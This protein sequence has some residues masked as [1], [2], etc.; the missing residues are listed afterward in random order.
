VSSFNTAGRSEA[1]STR[2]AVDADQE[3]LTEFGS[4]HCRTTIDGGSS[5]D[6]DSAVADNRTVHT[7]CLP[8]NGVYTLNA[9]SEIAVAGDREACA[10][11]NTGCN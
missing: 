6:T 1:T 9:G 11:H 4:E 7:S 2:H 10:E 5:L 3:T 8:T